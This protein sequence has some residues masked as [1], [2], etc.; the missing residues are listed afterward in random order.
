MV[1]CNGSRISLGVYVSGW[2]TV[3]YFQGWKVLLVEL[4]RCL[5]EKVSHKCQGSLLCNVWVTSISRPRNEINKDESTYKLSPTMAPDDTKHA[6]D[7][8]LQSTKCNCDSKQ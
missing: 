1:V 3:V 5:Q 7:V 2:G 6:L 4:K 8:F